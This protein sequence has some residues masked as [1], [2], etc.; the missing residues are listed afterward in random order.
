M[1]QVCPSNVAP[2]TMHLQPLLSSN[3]LFF[4]T[5]NPLVFF[6]FIQDSLCYYIILIIGTVWAPIIDYFLTNTLAGSLA[7]L[8]LLHEGYRGSI[9]IIRSSMNVRMCT[10]LKMPQ[11]VD[12]HEISKDGGV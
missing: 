7:M 12:F 9:K 1:A 3:L 10:S 8:K 2:E 6:L 4:F 11:Q 5:G